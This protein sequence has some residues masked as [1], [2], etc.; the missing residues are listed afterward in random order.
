MGYIEKSLGQDETIEHIGSIHWV[1]YLLPA[2]LML[3]GVLISLIGVLG[4]EQGAIVIGSLAIVLGLVS[5]LV[6]FVM[7]RTTELA[8][9]NKKVVAKWGLIS[10]RTIEQRLDKVDSVQVDQSLVGRV[11]GFGTIIVHGSGTSLTPI[12]RIM[13]PLD[14]RRQVEAAIEKSGPRSD[15]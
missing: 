5:F 11:L 3:T 6:S 9:T 10:R 14:F 8:V 2:I 7:R 1:I 4:D 12:T 13:A 15:G